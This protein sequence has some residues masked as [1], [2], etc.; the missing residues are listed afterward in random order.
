MRTARQ[1][2][3]QGHEKRARRIRGPSGLDGGA[4]SGGRGGPRC[5][6]ALHDHAVTSN[7]RLR[8]PSWWDHQAA[9][10]RPRSP[11]ADDRGAQRLPARWSARCRRDRPPTRH[12]VPVKGRRAWAIYEEVQGRGFDQGTGD[13]GEEP[14]FQ[15]RGCSSRVAAC[16]GLVGHSPTF[17][18]RFNAFA[19]TPSA[20]W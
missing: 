12:G 18:L 16:V 10:C 15:S 1:D 6:Q 4:A 11:V 19:G 17:R 8:R 13:L 2:L 5:R 9:L 7:Q 20:P 3:R 14:V